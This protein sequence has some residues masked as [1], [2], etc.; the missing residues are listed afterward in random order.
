MTVPLA[1]IAVVNNNPWASISRVIVSPLSPISSERKLPWASNA[2]VIVERLE[3]NSP[4]NPVLTSPIS[5]EIV[6]KVFVIF[7]PESD[8]SPDKAVK[9]LTN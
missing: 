9:E 1:S 7:V 2:S 4:D 6:D 3:V 8:T 5:P